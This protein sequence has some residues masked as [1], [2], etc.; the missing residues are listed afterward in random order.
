MRRHVG[1]QRHRCRVRVLIVLDP[2]DGL[3]AC[4]TECRAQWPN[5]QDCGGDAD[6][7]IT[8]VDAN[9]SCDT[10]DVETCGVGQSSA[11]GMLEACLEGN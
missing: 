3:D 2:A 9:G 8:C 10:L 6:S 1:N 7:V 5:E 11:L 4:V